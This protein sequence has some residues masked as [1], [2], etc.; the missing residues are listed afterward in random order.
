MAVLLIGRGS[1]GGYADAAR[2]PVWLWSAAAMSALIVLGITFAAP[3]IGTTATIGILVAGN[4][5]MAAV[6][7]RFG[8][9]GLEKIAFRWARITGIVL[10]AAGRRV[11]E[12]SLKRLTTATR[13]RAGRERERAST[14]GPTRQRERDRAN[15]E[16]PQDDADRECE[17]L[18]RRA[19]DAEPEARSPRADEHQRV[20]RPGAEVGADVEGRRR[21]NQ[22]DP[23]GEKHDPRRQPVVSEVAHSRDPRQQLD[24]AADETRCAS[25]P[26]SAR[27]P[28]HREPMRRCLPKQHRVLATW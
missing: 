20:A 23:H 13:A 21:P 11:E 1:F 15:A 7:D 28:R 22:R 24:E 14:A 16:R 12:V 17:D 9:F 2:Q 4:L 10:L 8:F 27:A 25:D 3:R 5:A 18:D 19:D 6:V 26:A